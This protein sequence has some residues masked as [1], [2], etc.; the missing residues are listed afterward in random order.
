MLALE[1]AIRCALEQDQTKDCHVATCQNINNNREIVPAT[2]R[3]K[4]LP[5]MFSLCDDDPK[6]NVV[7]QQRP[8]YVYW[9][10]QELNKLI[11]G[12]QSITDFINIIVNGAEA[13]W[14]RND[15]VPYLISHTILNP[16]RFLY[17][18]VSGIRPDT[19]NKKSF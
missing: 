2:R 8:S 14:D 6:E 18:F 7:Q 9:M 13:E 3:K 11:A 17:T 15:P 5:K 4:N 12:R 1:Q 16:Q 10:P 19:S